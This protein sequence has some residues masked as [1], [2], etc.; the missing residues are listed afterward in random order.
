MVTSEDFIFNVFGY[1][2][3]EGRL[4][5]FLKYIPSKFRD[6]FNVRLLKRTWKYSGIEF[7]RAEKL[8]T[9]GNYRVLLKTFKENFPNYVY[10][11]PFRGKEVI[12]VPLSHVKK[13][14]T[15]KYCLQALLERQNKDRLQEAALD[16]IILISDVSNVPVEDFGLHGSIA[17]S[18]YSEESDIDIVVYGGNNFRRVEAAIGK[19]VK[20]GLFSYIFKNRLDAARRYR[21]RYKD[22]I[23]MYTAV[24]RS[25]EINVRY[26]QYY[27]TPI[28]PVKFT[29]RVRDDSEAMFRPAIYEIEDYSPTGLDSDMSGEVVPRRVV[30]MVGCY[31]NVA[32]RGDEI[33]VSG[34]LER[35]KDALSGD[36]FY[37]VVVGTAE[38]GDEYIWPI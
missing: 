12:S 5:T 9:A 4:F 37:Q 7:S 2:H 23:F 15:P 14:F 16:L 11:C 22:K 1:E 30:S 24:R 17:L 31:R 35:V 28:K 20:E 3:P 19:L 38:G 33:R 25:E 13:V 32:R 6:L 36:V 34:I 26:G 8:Y 27:Y 10:F 18:M 29:C 21:V